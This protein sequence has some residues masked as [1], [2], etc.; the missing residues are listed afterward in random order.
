MNTIQ[1]GD[2]TVKRIGLGTNRIRNDEDSKQALLKAVEFGINFFDTASAYT[3]GTSEEMIGNTLSPFYSEVVISTKGG[4]KPPD[5][6][7]DGSPE[8]L[9]ASLENSLRKLKLT[10]I[11]LYFLHRVDPN[12]PLKTSVMFLK[13]MQ[14]EGKIKHIGLSEVSVEQ[15][16]EARKYIKV[17][18]VQNEYNLLERK[19]EDVVEYCE[20]EGIVFIPWS[21]IAHGTLNI[22]TEILEKYQATPTQLALAWLLHRSPMILPIPGSTSIEHIEENINSLKISLNQEDFEKLTHLTN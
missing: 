12:I 7:V 15:I 3:G 9:K 6:A 21:P 14:V 11:P 17:I 22:P 1:I 10:Q 18:V 16:Q 8:N 5:F 20:K 2:L 13:Q 19:Y 4:M